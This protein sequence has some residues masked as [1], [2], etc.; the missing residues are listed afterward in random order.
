VYDHRGTGETVVPVG[1][2]THEAMVDDVFAVMDAMSVDR[3]VLAGF[4]RGVM[5]VMRAVLRDPS[6]FDG[7]ILMNGTGEVMVP[8]TT[9]PPRAAPS[10]WPGETHRDRLR[11]FIERCTPEPDSEHIRRWGVN[12]LSRATPEAAERIMTM[13]FEKP[14]DWAR[15][16]PGLRLP[17]LLLHGEKDFAC[18]LETQRY[19]Q[20]LI[21]GSKLV[22][23]DG[24]GHVPAMVQPMDVAAAIN[25]YFDP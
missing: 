23:F 17:T 14:V 13:H 22:V 9:P 1:N 25:A 4:S 20:S 19:I 11:W 10:N 15:E 2:I 8:G 5:T 6:R 18:N 16:L 24:A 7:L 3:C 21:P 12:I